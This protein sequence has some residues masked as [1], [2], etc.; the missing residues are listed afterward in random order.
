MSFP[1]LALASVSTSSSDVAAASGV[2]DLSPNFPPLDADNR[3]ALD[4]SLALNGSLHLLFA[5][6]TDVPASRCVVVTGPVVD[7]VVVCG[8]ARRTVE[9]LALTHEA[10]GQAAVCVTLRRRGARLRVA[11]ADGHSSKVATTY[12]IATPHAHLPVLFR[13]DRAPPADVYV[14][15]EDV[16]VRLRRRARGDVVVAADG[17]V[18]PAYTASKLW[19]AAYE[20]A[21][22][23]VQRP[24]IVN[25]KNVVELG[26]GLGFAGIAAAKVGAHV[27]ATDLSENLPLLRDHFDAND[28][29]ATCE[30]LD[31]TDPTS[32][33][34]ATGARY[35]VILAADCVFWPR[36]FEPLIDT[37]DVLAAPL[38]LIAVTNRL[39]R[40]ALFL[41]ALDRRG[42]TATP[43]ASSFED[44]S[45]A[46]NTVVFA[47]NRRH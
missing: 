24:H 45:A 21:R 30:P 35:D 4:V 28:V 18:E 47:V 16:V 2:V 43:V 6:G 10:R 22:Y 23:L 46:F 8:C 15:G 3:L 37:L 1:F 11:S 38:V 20:L 32:S 34:V 9:L 40:T 5:R 25:G 33:P 36:L 27:V 29:L 39:D 44:V 13:F 31:W 7:A 19:P 41:G 42:W 12:P 26:A 17:D 14:L